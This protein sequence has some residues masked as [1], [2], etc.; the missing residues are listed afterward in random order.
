[1]LEAKG[2]G[3]IS[4]PLSKNVEATLATAEE[5]VFWRDVTLRLDGALPNTNAKLDDE[6]ELYLGRT[7]DGRWRKYVLGFS[8]LYDPRVMG[9][10][11]RKLYNWMDDE[12]AVAEVREDGG[13]INLVVDMTIHPDHWTSGGKLQAVIDVVR[14]G[15]RLAGTFTGFFDKAETD[16][17]GPAGKK[18]TK[19]A[20]TGRVR[21]KL[22][23]SP[24]EGHPGPAKPGE[25]PR[26]LFRA[27]DLPGVKARLELP[28]GKAM[29][30]IL[31]RVAGDGSKMGTWHGYAF[32]LLHQ[33]TGEAK[34]AELA[35]K[36]A[37]GVISGKVKSSRYGW[38][39]RDGGYMR[40]APSAAAV[41][42]AYDMC[43]DA[44]PADFRQWVA[45]KVQDRVC[46]RM[47][48]EH[49]QGESDAQ[50]TQRSNHYGLWQGGAGMCVAAIK[51]DPGT[52]EKVLRRSHRIFLR[53]LKRCL[54]DGF[55][56]HG[57]FYEGTFC[58]RFPTTG[59]INPYLHALR[60]AEGKDF[61]TNCS[62]AC[63]LTTK[64]IYE[65]VRTGGKV[66]YHSRGMYSKLKW[67]GLSG[68]FAQGFGLAPPEHV[69]A[70]LWFYNHVMEP[71]GVRDFGVGSGDKAAMNAAYAFVNWPVGLKP[72]DPGEVLGHCLYDREASFFVLRSGW[73]GE[74]D[75]VVSMHGGAVVLGMGLE[76]T[77]PAG[78]PVEAEVTH[79]RDEDGTVVIRAVGKNGIAGAE[80]TY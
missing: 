50:F 54:A 8:G 36:F 48:L 77:F 38:F 79:F 70:I 42:A 56:D 62:E 41:A 57:W 35:R 14:E 27:G 33:L 55:G 12:G 19:G 17:A 37:E 13:R 1:R 6:L 4:A 66:T 18:A 52:D 58:G 75:V 28:E 60:V 71:D 43:Y 51:G 53:R 11:K 32:G 80:G 78:I 30:A 40:S 65:F 22:W 24:V 44:W 2:T 7:D 68:D 72:K 21:P 31:E 15:D 26:L 16:A 47:V 29:F 5:D 20:V 67:S 73:R 9:V 74:G 10:G 76:G 45:R 64:W 63:W 3:R 25:H 69:P 46:P 34:W 61:V 39:T 23:P 49:D 59:G